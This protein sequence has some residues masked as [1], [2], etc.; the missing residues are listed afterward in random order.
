MR[1]RLAACGRP[2]LWPGNG[3][4]SGQGRGLRHRTDM[5][6]T[7]PMQVVAVEGLSAHCEAKGVTRRVSLFLLQHE[8][9]VPGDMLLI[10][11]D[12][13]VQKVSADEAR[14]TWALVDEILGSSGGETEPAAG[15]GARTT[16]PTATR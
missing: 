9:I 14:A 2:I 8:S 6:F 10:H 15:P 12:S 4:T 1:H 5:C 13:A 11:L 7:I 3:A 16:P